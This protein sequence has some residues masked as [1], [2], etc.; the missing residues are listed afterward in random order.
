M[1]IPGPDLA[2]PVI[3]WAF[4]CQVIDIIECI[5]YVGKGSRDEFAVMVVC[6]LNFE[7]QVGKFFLTINK[8]LPGLVSGISDQLSHRHGF[9]ELET[10]GD[11]FDR[12]YSDF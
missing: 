1:Q 2:I 11:F 12:V 9:V 8:I 3:I 4:T 5:I 6:F 10:G 7:D